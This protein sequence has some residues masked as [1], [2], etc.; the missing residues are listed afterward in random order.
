MVILA[1]RSVPLSSTKGRH[2]LGQAGNAAGKVG[3]LLHESFAGVGI[4]EVDGFLRVGG[5]NGHRVDG[6]TGQCRC[7]HECSGQN[8]SEAAAQRDETA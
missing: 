7:S 2:H 8:Q 4:E 6:E 1:L 3:V 5:L